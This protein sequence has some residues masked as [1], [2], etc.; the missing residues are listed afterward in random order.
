MESPQMYD[1]SDAVVKPNLL[2]LPN[3]SGKLGG[4]YGEEFGDL[5]DLGASE[6]SLDL[7]AFVNDPHFSDGI[8][9]D[10]VDKSLGV[11]LGSRATPA[12][13]CSSGLTY[14]SGGY[15]PP[16]QPVCSTAPRPA[17]GAP[18]QAQLPPVKKDPDGGEY[19]PYRPP[20]G[21]PA[22]TAHGP[23]YTS[24]TP[25]STRPAVAPA[26]AAAPSP[27]PARPAAKGSGGGGGGGGSKR[28]DRSSDEYRRRRERNNVAVRRSREKA[29]MRSRE[30]EERV[31]LLTRENDG[32]HKRIEMLSKELG[33][34]KNLFA[35]VGVLPD[36]LH[37][38]I[39]KHL[40]EGFNRGQA[41]SGL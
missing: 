38:E 19:Q 34:L 7:Q 29:K 13:T 6:V 35:N 1:L 5:A 31:K 33:V 25:A 11:G 12:A 16:A 4:P 10:I 27:A 15:L 18:P 3:K 30:T 22:V 24:L 17:A 8:F 2:N 32:L 26:A 37:R 21:Y 40:G 28:I 9:P 39:A 23:A 20:A 36:Q 14:S 41:P